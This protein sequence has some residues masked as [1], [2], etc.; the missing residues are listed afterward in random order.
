MS[1]V[2][3]LRSRRSRCV[4][5]GLLLMEML[6]LLMRSAAFIALLAVRLR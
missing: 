2:S 1:S 4:R 3:G 5:R 6:S